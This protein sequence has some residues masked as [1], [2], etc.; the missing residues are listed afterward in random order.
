LGSGGTAPHI[1]NLVIRWRWVVSF[2]HRPLYP[3]GKKRRYPLH[4]RLCGPRSLSGHVGKEKS[5]S[6]G[7][8][9]NPGR[10]V[11]SLAE[12]LTAGYIMIL[13][14]TA[15]RTALG[16]TQPPIQWVPGDLSLGVKR[17]GCEADHS[18][19]SS[20]EVK[21][22]VELYLHSPTTPSWRGA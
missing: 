16:P 21:E 7:R 6:P 2:I 12:A 4:R 18:P 3:R 15:S 1:L 14:T 5:L 8:E 20:A 10:P 13:F 17:Q 22:C 19:P 9:S 11:C